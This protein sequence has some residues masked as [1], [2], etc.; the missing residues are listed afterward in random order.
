M[1]SKKLKTIAQLSIVV[2]LIAFASCKKLEL[3]FFQITVDSMS[4]PDT[5]FC[6]PDSVALHLYGYIGPNDCYQFFDIHF[7]WLENDDVVIE[8]VGEKTKNKDCG[9][10]NSLL[11]HTFYLTFKYPGKYTFYDINKSDVELGRIVVFP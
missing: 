8:V 1:Y 9:G 10:G 3:R 7:Y 2:C 5:A 11:D 6:T 4:F